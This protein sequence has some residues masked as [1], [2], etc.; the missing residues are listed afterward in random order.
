MCRL[1]YHPRSRDGYPSLPPL[2]G[3]L[4]T[5]LF[6]SVSPCVFLQLPQCPPSSAV[7]L[8]CV[9]EIRAVPQRLPHLGETH[10][11]LITFVNLPFF[12]ST[13]LGPLAFAPCWRGSPPSPDSLPS[14][15]LGLADTFTHVPSCSCPTIPRWCEILFLAHSKDVRKKWCL[16]CALCSPEKNITHN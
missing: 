8:L 2:P 13:L 5:L 1:W 10:V 6:G 14:S 9:P 4:V 16:K 12:L 15:W 7:V 3:L 11:T